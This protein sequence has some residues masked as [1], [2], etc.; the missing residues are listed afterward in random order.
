MRMRSKSSG[1]NA[2]S[3]TRIGKR[4]CSSGIRSDGLL[5]WKAPEATNKIWSVRMTPCLV[6]TVQP[7]MSGNKSRCTP[8]RDT[9]APPVSWRLATLSISSIKTM[10]FCS[11]ASTARAFSSSSLISLAA[12]SSWSCLAAALTVR[13]RVFLRS[14]PILENMPCS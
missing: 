5:R 2:E 4:P 14:P 13:R 12:S 3:S 8:S 11:A 9:S 10:P 6:L 1:V 7:S